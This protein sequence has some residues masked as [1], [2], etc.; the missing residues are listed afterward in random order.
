M[1]LA[2]V[3]LG[4][5]ALAVERAALD[6]GHEVVLRIGRAENPGGSA[7]TPERLSGVDVAVEFTVPGA[8]PGNL[9]ALARAGVPTV[10]GTTGW[11]HDLPH[12]TAQVREHGSSLLHASN[13]SLGVALFR[14][15]VKQAAE[16]MAP[17]QEYDP[18][19]LEIHHRHKVDHPS[20]TARDLA[21]LLVEVLPAKGHWAA[22]QDGSGPLEKDTL[23]VGWLRTGE[24]P[25]A[26]AVMFEGPLD[27]I[28]LRHEA[29][30]RSVFALGALRAAEWLPGRTGV[31]TLD[32]L[33][34]SELRREAD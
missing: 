22:P 21:E 9:M 7:L 15:L 16:L 6:R 29:R 5:M 25:G 20:G 2:L 3:G 34:D 31:F 8:A 30:D 19:L 11:T 33:L 24:N 12:V 10:S 1:K 14:R 4:R 23:S 26:H 13:F 17:F 27:R 32:D 18:A 28:E